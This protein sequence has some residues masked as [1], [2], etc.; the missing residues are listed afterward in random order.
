MVENCG[1]NCL[2]LVCLSGEEDRTD[3]V[4]NGNKYLLNRSDVC[5]VPKG[6]EWVCRRGFMHR[7]SIRNR[8][9][10]TDAQFVFINIRSDFWCVCCNNERDIV[11]EFGRR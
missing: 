1:D 2:I 10:S 11:Q 7:Y 8:S 9:Q 4:I 6:N 3:V 5:W